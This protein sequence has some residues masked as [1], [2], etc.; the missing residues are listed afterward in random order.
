[1]SGVRSLQEMVSVA[2]MMDYT[3]VHF[4]ALCRIVSRRSTLY[5]EMLVDKAVVNAE[6]E[7][8]VAK[9][10]A[11]GLDEDDGNGGRVVGDTVLQLGGSDPKTMAEAARIAARY[12]YASVNVNC[13]CPSERVA[14]GG[15][16][17]AALM[18]EPEI[19]REI[20]ERMRDESGME[21]SVK[22][23][24]GV[25][26]DDSYAQLQDFV[27][28]CARGGAEHIIV[29]ARKAMLNGLSPAQNRSVPPLHYGW[30]Y[31]LA[32]EFPEMRF[33]LNGGI[34]SL[35]DARALLRH[36]GYGG[37]DGAPQLCGVMLGRAVTNAP[38]A[39][40][41]AVD[42][43]VYG[44]S[45]NPLANRREALRQYID[46]CTRQETYDADDRWRPTERALLKPLH[47]LFAGEPN[48]KRWR[49]RMDEVLTRHRQSGA[50][51]GKGG[52]MLRV[53][54]VLMECMETLPAHVLD[55]PP[56][57]VID[58]DGEDEESEQQKMAIRLPPRPAPSSRARD[59]VYSADDE[60][61]AVQVQRIASG[62]RH[63]QR[64]SASAV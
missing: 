17:G 37:I 25:D 23:R 48:G 16:F 53:E 63:R 8:R 61:K 9:M 55:A 3:D 10:L 52:T 36:E 64:A 31:A 30:A 49:C 6:K 46:Y 24:L 40:L 59:A 51:N 50:A 4:R 28:A 26:E 47:G 20:V 33:T 38:W 13:G 34:T 29:H 42:T 14:G 60:D 35:R 15:R 41:S 22:C 5:T 21:V 45:A 11:R 56:Q 27:R 32:D 54:D 62:N 1:M 12:G 44:E 7:G 58:D 43:C 19:V 57:L 18:R 39:I 2:P